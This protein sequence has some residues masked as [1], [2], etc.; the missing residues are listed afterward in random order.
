VSHVNGTPTQGVPSRPFDLYIFDSYL[1][2]TLPDGDMLII[3]PPRSTDLFTRGEPSEDT[4]NPTIVEPNNDIVTFLNVEN[5]NIREFTPVTASW[6]E[7][8]VTVDGGAVILAGENRGRQVGVIAFGLGDSDLPLQIAFPILMNNFMD[9]YRPESVAFTETAV[10]TGESLTITPPVRAD[11]VRVTKPNGDRREF[12]LSGGALIYADTD[13]L[14]IYE[15]G[16][17]D[18]SETLQEAQFAV[19]LFDAAESDIVPRTQVQLGD[20]VIAEASGEEELGQREFWR[21]L[22][23]AALLILVA[24]WFIYH[25]RLAGPK[26]VFRPLFQGRGSTA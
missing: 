3:N 26:G 16:I 18:G 9:W 25:R 2:D 20:A 19:N 11:R 7:P 1:P 5:L 13:Q 8:L 24:E 12:E 6:L 15:V 4:A 17:F 23:L 10:R 21:W 14:G 22:A